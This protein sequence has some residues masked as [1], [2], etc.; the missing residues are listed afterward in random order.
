MYHDVQDSIARDLPW[1]PIYNTK[2]IVVTSSRVKGF[3]VHPVEYNLALWTVS[4]ER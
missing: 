1:I 4:I 2:E 3:T